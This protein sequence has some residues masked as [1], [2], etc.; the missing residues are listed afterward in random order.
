LKVSDK[1]LLFGGNSL[2]KEKGFEYFFYHR[3]H[4]VLSNFTVQVKKELRI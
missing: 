2:A 3:Q 4:L 1:F